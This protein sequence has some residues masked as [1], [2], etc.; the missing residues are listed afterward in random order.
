MYGNTL[1]SQRVWLASEYGTEVLFVYIVVHIRSLEFMAHRKAAVLD[2][3]LLY[4]HSLSAYF[5]LTVCCFYYCFFFCNVFLHF[6]GYICNFQ[7]LKF[8]AVRQVWELGMR[9]CCWTANL[10][11]PSRWMIWG[12]RLK[13][14]HWPWA[15]AP[16]P[17]WTRGCSAPFH[18]V[19]P[20]GS[21]TRPRTSSPRTKVKLPVL[22]EQSCGYTAW[23][24]SCC[25]Y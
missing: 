21:R 10:H 14:K 22:C 9:F 11:L 20:M 7:Q 25:S 15:S 23:V 5:P 8:L 2:S 13:T 12:L 4:C 1:E 19:A 24:I 18:P 16:C 6:K 17:S 3:V